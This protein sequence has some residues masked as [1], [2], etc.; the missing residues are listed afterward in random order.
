MRAATLLA[1]DGDEWAR[2]FAADNSGTYNNEFLV[3][4]PAAFKP[5]TDAPLRPGLLTVVDQ[6]PGLVTAA[7]ATRTLD[8]GYFPSYNLPSN[9][10]VYDKCGLSDVDAV[11]GVAGA[12][13]DTLAAT[14][15]LSYQAA[16]RAAIFR[17]DGGGV[18]SLARL[19]DVMRSVYKGV[20]PAADDDDDDDATTANQSKPPTPLDPLARGDAL[21]AV[22]GRADLEADP[23]S[24]EPR[25]CFDSKATSVT[26][27]RQLAAD[28]V[29]GPSTAGGVLPPFKPADW[30]HV[31]PTAGMPAVFNFDWERTRPRLVARGGQE[32]V[33]V[34]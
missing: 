23:A 22:C 33:E 14:R 26:L 10:R 28:V 2:V 13:D 12:L 15:W 11:A 6:I 1:R 29:T 34:A 18:D 19:R 16:P 27:A 30:A 5:D 7:D 3:V 4:T 17:R 8:R 21:A 9:P 32:G 24:R 20:P 31:I 25:G